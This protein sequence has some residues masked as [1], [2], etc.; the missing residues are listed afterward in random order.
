MWSSVSGHPLP[1]SH[2]SSWGGSQLNMHVAVWVSLVLLQ[3]WNTEVSRVVGE[4]I[5]TWELAK[6]AKCYR[7]S[8]LTP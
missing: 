2:S 3:L 5:V 7:S 1:G 4:E 6:H 8:D